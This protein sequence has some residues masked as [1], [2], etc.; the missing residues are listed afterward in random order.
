MEEIA[1]ARLQEDGRPGKALGIDFAVDVAQFNT[2]KR[3]EDMVDN[4]DELRVYHFDLCG[5]LFC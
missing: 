5:A 3:K 1:V 4:K 2:Y